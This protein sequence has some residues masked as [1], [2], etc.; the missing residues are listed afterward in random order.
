MPKYVT[1]RDYSE[2]NLLRF[3]VDFSGANVPELI[4]SDLD[5]DPNET[6]EIFH[7]KVTEI[8]NRHMPLTKKKFNR[9]HDKINPWIT[10]ALMKSVNHKNRLYVSLSKMPHNSPQRKIKYQE[11]KAYDTLLNKTLRLRKKRI[12]L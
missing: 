9:K 7:E 12:I 5:R 6:Y 10:P 4:G 8:R 3:A 11:F 2:L 1:K